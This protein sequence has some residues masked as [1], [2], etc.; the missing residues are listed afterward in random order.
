[1]ERVAGREF[2]HECLQVFAKR[3]RANEIF[4]QG[5]SRFF[6]EVNN[7][8]PTPCLVIV[9]ARGKSNLRWPL[10]FWKSPPK[11]GG[12]GDSVPSPK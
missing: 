1:M 8:S 10:L 9:N 2:A 5:S 6:Q 11:M 12:H 7:L 3:N 4:K